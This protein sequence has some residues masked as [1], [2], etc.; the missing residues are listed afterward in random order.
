MK[1]VISSLL[2][3]VLCFSLTACNSAA[4]TETESNISQSISEERDS[5]LAEENEVSVETQ[6]DEIQK[7]EDSEMEKTKILVAYFSHTGENYS[8][9]YIEKGNTHIIADMIIGQTSGDTFEIRT[10]TP[11]PDSYDECT[12]IA[13]QEQ[14]ENTRPELSEN[15]EDIEN[16]D[17]VFLGYPNWWDDM[18]MAV[19]T[20]LES[21]DFFGK[22]IV[23]FCTHEGSGL[24][25]TKRNIAEICPDAEVLDGLAVRGSVA[26]NSQDEANDAVVHWLREAGFIE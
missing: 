6:N 12:E 20:F 17:V 11:Y 2:A 25:S 26:Q 3:F 18:P 8:V 4:N 7:V 9:G 16:Y 24:S 1:K 22:T 23:P 21:Y 5:A 13:K 19:Y 10:V 15:M 14:N